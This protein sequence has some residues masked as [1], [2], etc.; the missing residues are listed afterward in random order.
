MG[1]SLH[2]RWNGKQSTWKLSREK[3]NLNS[4][5]SLTKKKQTKKLKMTTK[6]DTH[7][8]PT[9]TWK[10]AQFSSIAQS[11]P[12]LCDPMDCSTQGLP[13][14]HQL[15]EF[16]QN[17]VHWVSDTIQQSH[18]LS[19]PSLPHS[20]FPR[21]RVFS[22]ESALLRQVLEFQFQHQ[23]FQRIFRTDFL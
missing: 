21:I 11:C 7:I 4:E 6:E 17:L 23:A 19:S 3:K 10:G 2:S 20:I 14:H 22:N 9:S 12:T 15:L 5:N 16:T 1:E 18:P 13:A 8:W